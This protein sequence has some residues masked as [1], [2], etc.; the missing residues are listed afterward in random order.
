M[1]AGTPTITAST[2]LSRRLSSEK[3]RPPRRPRA[4]GHLGRTD[5]DVMAPAFGTMTPRRREPAGRPWQLGGSPPVG[6]GPGAAGRGGGGGFV[7]RSGAPG[8]LAQ[9]PPRVAG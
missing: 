3:R 7:E 5:S 1:N 6:R 9:A 4:A 2:I 8:G